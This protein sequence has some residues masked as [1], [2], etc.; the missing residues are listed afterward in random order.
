MNSFSFHLVVSLFQKRSRD[1]EGLLGSDGVIAA[2]VE[3]VD[4]ESAVEPLGT[5]G[6]AAEVEVGVSG[7]GLLNEKGSSDDSGS[8][9]IISRTLVGLPACQAAREKKINIFLKDLK[10]NSESFHPFI[11]CLLCL[12]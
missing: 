7:F 5:F 12:S 9:D 10:K 4:E 2:D 8:V 1:V 3:A 11:R 6:R